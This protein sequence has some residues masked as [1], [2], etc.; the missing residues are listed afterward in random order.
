MA[1]EFFIYARQ[2]GD[3]DGD[4]GLDIVLAVAATSPPARPRVEL[5][6]ISLH[7]GA[8]LW[9]YPVRFQDAG[10]SA[11]LVGD[12]DGDAKAEVVLKDRLAD[13]AAG[14]EV[15]ALDGRDGSARWTW[16]GGD[17]WDER[18]QGHLPFCLINLEGNGRRSVCL[19]AGTSTGTRRLVILDAQGKERAARDLA[20]SSFPSVAS[21]RAGRDGR[22]VMLTWE[23]GRLRASTP[24]LKEL[25]S[26]PCLG[27]NRDFLPLPSG[28]PVV[29]IENPLVGIDAANGRPIWAGGLSRSL[30]EDARNGSLPRV[31]SGPK[32]ATV[33]RTSLPVSPSGSYASVLGEPPTAAPVI[34]RDD[35]RWK[36]HLPWLAR[37]NVLLGMLVLAFLALINIVVPLTVLRFATRK[38]RGSMMLLLTLPIVVAIPLATFLAMSRTLK[39]PL[40]EPAT[41]SAMAQLA[42][43][44]LGG[45][46]VLAFAVLAGRCCV[47][48]RSRRLT[49]LAGLTAIAS[50]LI[51]AV[52][53]WF[54][55]KSM[56]ALEHYAW[57]GW[58]QIALP[59]GYAVGTLALVAWLVSCAWGLLKR[60]LR[61]RV[62]SASPS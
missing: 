18:A 13:G 48:R 20:F 23:N 46:P 53:M 5:R 43:S 54:D 35:Q 44:S 24:D 7:D 39:P 32:G 55:M 42:L 57:R 1:T 56:V 31:L 59:G 61:L 11:F 30:L 45:L 25:W 47:R 8:P 22:E 27:S 15:T 34:A 29:V 58:Y 16:R 41:W 36:R 17:H 33:C 6:A 49:W 52:W 62:A 10:Y 40:E 9:S 51:A 38:R 4:G 21:I 2:A 3:L 26:W 14:M 19:N 12:L 60:M 28:R 50:L 37:G